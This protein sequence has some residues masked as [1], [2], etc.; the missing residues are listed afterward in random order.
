MTGTTR[1]SCVASAALALA[2]AAP[3]RAW[4]VRCVDPA[5]ASGEGQC[6]EDPFAHAQTPWLDHPLA[7]HRR[8]LEE[9][10]E[11][12][13]LPA[14]ALSEPFELTVYAGSETFDAAGVVYDSV[15]PLLTGAE[16][17]RSRVLTVA[18]MASLPDFSY[19][20]WDWASGN[21]V[22]PP[23]PANPSPLDC[24]TYET[25]IGWL[26]SNHMLPQARH[27]Y[28]YLH[29]LALERAEA[30]AALHARLDD[31]ARTRFL[32]WLLA[33]EKETL[34]LEGVAQHYLQ[35]AWAIGHM[36]ERWGSTEIADFG[37][38]Q[39]L[40]FAISGFVGALHGSKAMLDDDPLTDDL[41]PWDDPLNAP[42]EDVGY[43]DALDG[44]VPVPRPGVG[45]RFLP[46]LMGQTPGLADYG[47]QREALFGCA[48]DGLRAVYAATAQLHGELLDPGPGFDLR[49]SVDDDSC[50]AQRV[51]N[52]GY[53]TGLGVHQGSFAGPRVKVLEGVTAWT[54]ASILGNFLLGAPQ[55]TPQVEQDFQRDIG[56]VQTL[57]RIRRNTHPDDAFLAAGEAPSLAGI[58][59]NSQY[60]RGGPGVPPAGYSDPLL[61]WGLSDPDSQVEER[62]QTLNLTFADAHAAD[63]CADFSEAD[64]EAYVDAA[65]DAAAGGDPE[66]AEAACGQC[67]QLVA[68]HLRFGV[69]GD[70]DPNREAFCALV[71]EPPLQPAFLYTGEDPVFTGSE[72]TDLASL[73][74]AARARCCT[75]VTPGEVDVQTGVF[76]DVEHTTDFD[77][78]ADTLGEKEG[79]FVPFNRTLTAT[80]LGGAASAGARMQVSES[81]GS[82]NATGSGVIDLGHTLNDEDHS[83]SGRA[84]SDLGIQICVT[85]RSSFSVQAQVTILSDATEE[86]TDAEIMFCCDDNGEEVVRFAS[87]A[88]G[89]PRSATLALN[90]FIGSR[91]RGLGECI[92]AGVELDALLQS[93]QTRSSG[94]SNLTVSVSPAP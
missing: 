19:T 23:A 82:A 54:L 37:G 22:C 20:L 31:E 65:R 10:L 67:V 45:D 76:L 53:D 74:A 6:P 15:R 50:W 84:Q 8:L 12:A 18:M 60:A 24:H 49:R 26:N 89:S 81:G 80:S 83:A 92:E 1:A 40:G 27:W 34:V 77:G 3:A 91:G 4:D 51:T 59:P 72:P 32:P 87:D 46:V 48:V 11:I 88:P 29:S 25:H 85:E 16:R 39:A 63:R 62:K 57:A 61:P 28:G 55:M 36:L 30:C 5:D 42:H 17:E 90:G 93:G 41:G 35:D 64:L 94:T 86:S 13:G 75:V 73:Q 21:E 69:E 47:A 43:L 79:R 70:H 78:E 33:C 9:S 7:E 58:G 2:L 52:R 68:P 38:N 14:A 66:A 56:F 44:P 71:A